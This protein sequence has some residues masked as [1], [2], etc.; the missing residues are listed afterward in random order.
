V[1]ENYDYVLLQ[2]P[3][4]DVSRLGSR[5][6]DGARRVGGVVAGT[7][8]GAAS[9]GW[10]DDE[11]IVLVGWPDQR[12]DATAWTQPIDPPATSVLTPLKATARPAAPGPLPR[13][14]VHAHRWLEATPNDIDEIVHLSAQAWPAFEASFEARIEGLFRTED[15]SGRLLLITWYSSVAEWERSRAVAGADRGSLAEARRHFQRRRQLT[16]RQVVR[17]APSTGEARGEAS[18]P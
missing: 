10:S 7:W 15:G 4:D 6:A 17:L 3:R 13:G 1:H 8:L 18:S 5:L 12:P 16:R 2:A 14:G 11:A 9:I